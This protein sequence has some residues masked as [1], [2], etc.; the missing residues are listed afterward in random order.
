MNGMRR[1]RWLIG[2]LLCCWPDCHWVFP[3]QARPS[4]TGIADRGGIGNVHGAGQD[5]AAGVGGD[6]D[7]GLFELGQV[8]VPRD[9]VAALAC[10]AL[11]DGSAKALSRPG[12]DGAL[13]G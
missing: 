7:C 4:A 8:D 1:S 10:E 12:N 3:Y 13:A 11:D 2:L 9:D 5:T 6:G